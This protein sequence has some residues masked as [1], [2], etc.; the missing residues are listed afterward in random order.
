MASAKIMSETITTVVVVA[1]ADAREIM[2]VE[3][4][5]EDVEDAAAVI[6]TTTII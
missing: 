4:A 1:A 2:D 3:V 5:D 6:M